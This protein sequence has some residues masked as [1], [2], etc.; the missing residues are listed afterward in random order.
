VVYIQ[1]WHI[2]PMTDLTSAELIERTFDQ[3]PFHLP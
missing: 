3:Y 2:S 1:V